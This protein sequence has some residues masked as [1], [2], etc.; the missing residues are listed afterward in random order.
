MR[1]G[2]TRDEAIIRLCTSKVSAKETVRRTGIRKDRGYAT[3]KEF[4]ETG[5]IPDLKLI[6]RPPK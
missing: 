1:S 5:H 4:D 2:E 6:R 3:I